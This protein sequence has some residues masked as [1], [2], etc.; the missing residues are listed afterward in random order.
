[1]KTI[2]HRG[3]AKL[4]A[5]VKTRG[6][7]SVLL[8]TLT[9]AAFSQFV[10]AKNIYIITDGDKVTVHESFTSNTSAVLNEAG[11]E[12][13]DED[14]VT[15]EAN[16]SGV[17]SIVISRRM[18]VNVTCD[19]NTLTAY[20]YDDE[21]VGALLEQL[22]ITLGELDKLSCSKT[23]SV[24]DGM[25]LRVTRGE[26]RLEETAKEIPFETQTV[27][28][29]ELKE[30]ETQ[31]AVQGVAGKVC[32]YYDVL[33][34]DGQ[35]VS[36]TLLGESVLKE[37]V[38]EVVEYGINKPSLEI[39]EDQQVLETYVAPK[40]TSAATVKSVAAASAESESDDSVSVS[41]SEN[42]I[43]TASGQVYSYS[44]VLSMEATAYCSSAT[45]CNITASGTVARV[46]A[47]AV[48]PSVIP[49][50]TRLYIVTNDGQY[51]YGY[52]VAEDT[53]AVI[54]GN[55]VDLYFNTTKECWAFGRRQCTVYMLD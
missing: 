33:Y 18:N 31:V 53:G 20:T 23:E 26:K 52:C 8:F 6:V 12:L 9:I 42:T 45:G 32:E 27:E 25:S 16:E 51:I 34:E 24:Y 44:K 28:T 5:M 13:E 46:G 35:E 54:K 29:A 48:D 11:F 10:T 50:G 17:Q 15:A 38:S 3:F 4:A 19:G 43:T 21:T 55:I 41:Q 49:L 30:G 40:A 2:R 37:P 39:H 22:N 14:I 1:M 47:I 7:A 36:R